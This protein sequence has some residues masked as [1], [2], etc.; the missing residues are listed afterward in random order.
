MGGFLAN[1]PLGLVYLGTFTLVVVSVEVGYRLGQYR[2]KKFGREDGQPIGEMVAATLSLLAFLL[3]FT[4][5]MASSRFDLRRELVLEEANAIGTCYL[6]ASFLEGFAQTQAQELLK[7]YVDLRFIEPSKRSMTDIFKRTS[8]IHTSL[9]EIT[10][11]AARANPTSIPIGHFITSLNEVI[12]LNEKRVVYSLGNRIPG[13][14]WVALYFV[15][16]ISMGTLGYHAGIASRTR[17]PIVFA[18]IIVFTAVFILI[19]DLDRG[20]E[21]LLRVNQSAMIDLRESLKGPQ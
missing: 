18:L 20:N 8:E 5:Q 11:S 3:A 12:D 21:G 13:T 7:E 19:A 10:K 6:R 1:I 14:I 16:A 2:Y 4:F 17:T 15:T 9:W